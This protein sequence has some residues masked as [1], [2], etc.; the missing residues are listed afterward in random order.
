M[1]W[2]CSSDTIMELHGVLPET[3][4][5]QRQSNSNNTQEF[6]PAH[7]PTRSLN[8]ECACTTATNPLSVLRICRSIRVNPHSVI[9]ATPVDD[10]FVISSS[11]FELIP[12][13]HN[14]NIY[15]SQRICNSPRYGLIK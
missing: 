2:A 5:H 15:Q 4:L 13:S 1:E 3:L 9:G 8:P 7:L 6:C 11:T 14:R 10:V 12:H